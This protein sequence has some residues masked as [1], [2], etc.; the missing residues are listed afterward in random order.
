[1]GMSDQAKQFL[2]KLKEV[3]KKT[4]ISIYL[5]SLNKSVKFLPFT[6]K[7]QKQILAKL[8]QDTSGLI[9]F[10]NIFNDII[11]ENAVESLDLNAI[12]GFDRLNIV[13]SYRSNTIG[14]KVS[15]DDKLVNINKVIENISKFDFTDKFEVTVIKNQ[16]VSAEVKLPSLSYDG[17]INNEITKKI[18]KSST[19]QQILSELF[20]SEV[21]KYIKSITIDDQQIELYDLAYDDKLNIIEQLP[22]SFIKLILKYLEDVKTIENTLTTVKGVKVEL[23]SELFS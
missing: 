17:K 8:P 5:P 22:G 11:S 20:T 18:N 21:L 10:N 7:Q 9:T 3:N 16:D 14:E 23:S 4:S 6:L 13:L 2:E 15:V 1:M 12:N 19:Q